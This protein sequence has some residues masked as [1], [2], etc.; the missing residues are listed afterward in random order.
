MLALENLK[1]QLG[2]AS[3][4]KGLDLEVA[5]GERVVIA[6]PSG[7]GK[8]TLLRVIAGL[9]EASEGRVRVAGEDVT[10]RPA[11]A[12]D[13][14]MMF[15]SYALFPHLSV[16][17]NLNFGLMARGASRADATAKSRAVAERLGLT[18]L[19]AQLP[20]RLSGGERQRVALARVLLKAP[21]V[22][23]LD[24]PLSNLD[25]QL[26]AHARGEI[27]KAH[28]EMNAAMLMVTHDQGEA[29]AMAHRIAVLQDGALVQ[30]AAPRSIYSKPRNLFVA[31]FFGTPE[32]NLLPVWVSMAGSLCW[33]Q[34]TLCT[35][36]ALAELLPAEARGQGRELL[37]GLRAEH[38]SPAASSTGLVASVELIEH[39]GEQ[40]IVW[41]Q[42]Q[43]QRLAMRLPPQQAVAV[44]DAL[45]LHLDLQHACWFDSKTAEALA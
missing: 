35:A 8:S 29:M 37:L 7:S 40:Q 6:G 21:K 15:Q 30:V 11:A 14:G 24:E 27:L 18:P 31:R 25:A 44:G 5:A 23:L 36:D 41:L 19:L 45:S 38:L 13:V 32:I 22:L 26:R 4:L 9:T 33:Q 12:R 3:I 20:R 28:A 42:C 39:L 10:E 34:H 1:V 43:G 16:L 17:E 2:A